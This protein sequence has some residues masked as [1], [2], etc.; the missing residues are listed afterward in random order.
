MEWQDEGL[1]IGVKKHGETSAIVELM[2]P[3]RGRHLGLV[4]GGRSRR[5]RPVL[6]AGNS[7]RAQWHARLEEHLGTYQLE[8][9]ELRVSNLMSTQIGIYGIQMLASHLRLLPERD[10]HPGLYRAACVIVDNLS[11]SEIVG[12]L[13][14]RFE[15][16]LL[17][18]LGFGLDLDQCAAT[19]TRE[20]LVF[21][22]PK[23]GRAVSRAAGQP[24]AEKMLALPNFLAREGKEWARIPDADNLQKGFALSSFFLD[25]H[26]YGPRAIKQPNERAGFITAVTRTG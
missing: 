18:E 4:R 1:I 23:S 22:S 3:E 24:W 2:T 11:Q 8:A 21:V 12:S 15:L 20:G 26:I 14:V 5:M 25:R 19:G 10:P 6:Q 16:A 17:E 7:V 13:M 9:Q